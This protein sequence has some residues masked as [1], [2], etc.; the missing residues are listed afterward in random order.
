MSRCK[1]LN[2]FDREPDHYGQDS[3]AGVSLKGW[4]GAVLAACLGPAVLAWL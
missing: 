2:G 3:W 4:C 1:Y